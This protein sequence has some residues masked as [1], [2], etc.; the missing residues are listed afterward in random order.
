M[1]KEICRKFTNLT[2]R[3]THKL[4]DLATG[5]SHRDMRRFFLRNAA[6]TELLASPY[7]AHAISV[8]AKGFSL[9]AASS[10]S[11]M[12]FVAIGGATIPALPA[13]AIGIP[14]YFIWAGLS[15]LLT[16]G[17]TNHP[18]T[19]FILQTALN[20]IMACTVALLAMMIVGLALS[21][22]VWGIAAATV[23]GT[24]L[25]AVR[26]V[27]KQKY[28]QEPAAPP[29]SEVGEATPIAPRS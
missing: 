24:I 28:T 18:H 15:M 2:E 29:V 9:S 8:A 19:R 11:H 21:P 3:A 5:D 16:A 14:A 27:L 26:T 22:A 12:G 1:I 25:T 10:V 17:C 6:T 20:I 4:T 23:V 13:F 7:T